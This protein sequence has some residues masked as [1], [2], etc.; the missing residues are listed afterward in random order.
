MKDL[1]AELEDSKSLTRKLSTAFETIQTPEF[2]DSTVTKVQAAPSVDK[3]RDALRQAIIEALKEKEV[4]VDSSAKVD[5]LGSLLQQVLKEEAPT[6]APKA[7]KT[8]RIM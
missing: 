3:K 1:R 4:S 5:E 2:V 6:S 7:T 8:G